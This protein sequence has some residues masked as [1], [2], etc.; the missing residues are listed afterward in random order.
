MKQ[1]AITLVSVCAL[2]G[3]GCSPSSEK[4]AAATPTPVPELT[5]E[6]LTAIKNS[7]EANKAAEQKK[8]AEF[9]QTDVATAVIPAE[10]AAAEAPREASP[11]PT[12]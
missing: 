8:K 9:S 1:I 4:T 12:P 3:A 5:A 7:S 10:P 2:L 6:Q 11:T